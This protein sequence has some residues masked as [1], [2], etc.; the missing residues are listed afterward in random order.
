MIPL[1]AFALVGRRPELPVR[2][3][4]H[5]DHGRRRPGDGEADRE[6]AAAAQL[7]RVPAVSAARPASARPGRARAPRPQ[8]IAEHLRHPADL[9]RRHLP[10]QRR[11]GDAARARGQG[12]HGRAASW[13]PTRS[14]TPW[15]A[16]GWREPDAPGGL[17]ARRL[18]A[19]GAA[20]RGAR[21]H[22]GRAA[23]S[24]RRRARAVVD[25]DEVVRRLSG[26]RTCTTCGHIWHVDFDPPPI[27]GVCDAAAASSTSATTTRRD[28]PAP[29]GGLRRADRAARRRLRRAAA[30]SSVD[31][32]GPVDEVT[33]ARD[34][35]AARSRRRLERG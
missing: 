17:P 4:Q 26:R 1:I 20:G 6:P 34:R 24:A 7:R 18:P 3:H 15:C 27:E 9:H 13:C 2:R 35:R 12:V 32:I 29:A 28:D 16:T 5:P 21:R 19:H 10:R 8:F 30:C 25:D 14:P 23:T 33:A 22:A 31:A 11:R